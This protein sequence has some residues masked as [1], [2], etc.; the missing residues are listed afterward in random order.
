[1]AKCREQLLA[2]GGPADAE[3]ETRVIAP[4]EVQVAVCC[5]G[6]AVTWRFVDDIWWYHV[7]SLIRITKI[8]RVDL[9]IQTILGPNTEE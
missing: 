4:G 6:G 5:S 2:C 3:L 1:M 8:L 7:L 9:D